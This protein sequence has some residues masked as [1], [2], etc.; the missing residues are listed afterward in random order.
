VKLFSNKKAI[1]YLVIH[2]NGAL[3]LHA[4]DGRIARVD[5]LTQSESDTTYLSDLVSSDPQIP[6]SVIV[7][8]FDE[9]FKQGNITHV[10]TMD[11]R[12]ILDR[13]LVSFFRVSN[14]RTS[15]IVGREDTGRRD[16]RAVFSALTQPKLIDQWIEAIV[17]KKGQIVAITS[18]SYLT[19]LWLDKIIPS[20][21]QARLI[22]TF[23]WFSGL[24]STFLKDGKVHFSRQVQRDVTGN[25]QLLQMVKDQAKQTRKYLESIKLITYE[26]DLECILISA[27]EDIDGSTIDL[28]PR[29]ILQ[30]H[31]ERHHENSE[32]YKSLFFS[33]FVFSSINLFEL[34]RASFNRYATAVT[35][36]YY[37]VKRVSSLITSTSIALSAFS[38]IAAL[39]SLFTYYQNLST[40]SSAQLEKASLTTNYQSMRERFPQTPVRSG[41]MQTIV[42]VHQQMSGASFQSLSLLAS[43][44]SVLATR[45]DIVLKNLAWSMFDRNQLAFSADITAIEA[46]T[47]QLVLDDM[48]GYVLRINA[49]IQNSSSLMEVNQRILSFASELN[50]S[51]GL[52]VSIL[53][54]PVDVD[55]SGSVSLELDG[56]DLSTG[57]TMLVWD[58]ST[59]DLRD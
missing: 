39:P 26:D 6:F 50:S 57:F 5:K 29:T 28:A 2:D 52:Q 27:V 34:N 45:P 17:H 18:T 46:N 22:I 10:S 53:E 55:P 24:R 31:Y 3:L 54:L 4:L 21:T 47:M 14:Y 16:D 59:S 30:V 48:A 40:I 1:R 58:T 41:L 49:E 37:S 23:D 9:E 19:E 15:T 8:C 33:A 20:A 38:L 36:R 13:K 32:L 51:A 25:E 56:G 43:F 7:D 42:E 12:S 11:S 35:T 44:S